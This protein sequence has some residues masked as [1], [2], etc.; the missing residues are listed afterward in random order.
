MPC[1]TKVYPPQALL[2]MKC[3]WMR[4]HMRKHVWYLQ[5]EG[6][7]KA[8]VKKSPLVD[9]DSYAFKIPSR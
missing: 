4:V 7:C 8:A 1:E 2:G 6:G 5:G 9:L 3:G